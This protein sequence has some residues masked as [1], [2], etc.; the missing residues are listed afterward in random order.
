MG[1]ADGFR[2][3]VK[4]AESG[5]ELDRQTITGMANPLRTE[6]HVILSER[7]ASVSGLSKDLGIT[8][9]QVRHEFDMLKAVR[10]IEIDCEVRVRGTGTV[11][12]FYRA[13]KRPHL[14][15]RE[16]RSVPEALHGNLRGSLLDKITKDAISAV[17]AGTYD[18]LE[19]AHM[20][21]TAGLVDEQGEKELTSWLSDCLEG[22]IKIFDTNRR[23]LAE[24]DAVG[25][26]GTV[27][28]LGYAST[29]PGRP[30]GPSGAQHLTK[31]NDDGG[32]GRRSSTAKK[33]PESRARAKEKR[34]KK[35]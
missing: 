9:D 4:W 26:A 2:D 28:I 21:R 6:I 30:A 24:K 14:S 18:S 10:L 23:R 7:S 15:R 11:E 22:V 27:S 20:S 32:D 35:F 29:I 13:V 33:T 34:G 8:Y 12:V 17:E 5:R 16:W 1:S 31:P 25:K 19:D 3:R